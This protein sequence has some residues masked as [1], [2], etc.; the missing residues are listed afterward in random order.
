MINASNDC[1]RISWYDL[2]CLF[3]AA[4]LQRLEAENQ[5][6]A[7]KLEEVVSKG[8]TLLTQIQQA[9]HDIAQ[10]QLQAQALET[11]WR[12]STCV[13]GYLQITNRW[14]SHK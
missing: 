6:A 1:I 4:S 12:H 2:V 9:L 11:D 7:R 3:Q 14:I 13:M 10:S 8:E 5:E